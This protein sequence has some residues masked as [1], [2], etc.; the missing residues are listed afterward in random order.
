MYKVTAVGRTTLLAL[1]PFDHAKSEVPSLNVDLWH[2]G[3]VT[4]NRASYYMFQLIMHGA[5]SRKTSGACVP[6]VNGHIADQQLGD[7]ASYIKF[8]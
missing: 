4:Q 6:Q 5:S 2:W 1:L 3:I 8:E 7:E